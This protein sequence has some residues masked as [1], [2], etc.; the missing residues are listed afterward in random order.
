MASRVACCRRSW[1]RIEHEGGEVLEPPDPGPL[2]HQRDQADR[3]R[4]SM[5]RRGS[6]MADQG[7]GECLGRSEH[8]RRAR[9]CACARESGPRAEAQRIY[10]AR[11]QIVPPLLGGGVT[12]DLASMA[13]VVAA[14]TS[15]FAATPSNY[16]GDGEATTMRPM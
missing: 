11:D 14:S 9:R 10:E 7:E 6:I 2:R 15:S 8:A 1:P 12:D 16:G 13:Y 5:S 4:S 3:Q